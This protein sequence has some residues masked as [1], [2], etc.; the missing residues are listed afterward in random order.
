MQ[1]YRVKLDFHVT[2]DQLEAYAFGQIAASD[3]H[4]LEGVEEHLMICS[5]CRD[6]LDGIEAFTSGLRQAVEPNSAIA[7]SKSHDLF[8]WLPWPRP[9]IRALSIGLALIAL[10]A[11]VVLFSRDQ[12]RF[13]PIANL[14]LSAARGEMAVSAPASELD[15]TLTG[16]P[17]DG[18]AFRS[19]IVN[20]TGG[21]VWN[22]QANQVS[23]V[24]GSI[25]VKA[26]QRFVPGD[27]FLR[28]YGPSGEVV[29]EYGFRI[30]Q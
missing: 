7:I 9:S 14:Q 21:T 19:R 20:A 8:A 11:I 13:I 12:T 17:A 24:A 1:E 3:T 10:I 15:V 30:R 6:R 22:G 2:E 25:V 26:Q 27:Y 4:V 5:A 18:Q 23:G 28:L 29:R 16:A